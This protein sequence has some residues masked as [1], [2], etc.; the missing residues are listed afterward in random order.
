[1]TR[2]YTI[3]GIDSKKKPVF[4][5]VNAKTPVDALL[6]MDAEHKDMISIEAI[7]KARLDD[8]GKLIGFTQINTGEALHDYE[9]RITK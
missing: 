6:A 1:M 7:L 5:R 4:F 9:M 2:R 3:L 8:N